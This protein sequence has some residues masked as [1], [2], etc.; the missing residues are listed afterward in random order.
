M[1]PPPPSPSLPSSPG[2]V[3]TSNVPLFCF[4][5]FTVFPSLHVFFVP[6]RSLPL[7]LSVSLPRS[8]GYLRCFRGWREGELIPPAIGGHSST[9]N[10]QQHRVSRD[11]RLAERGAR[12]PGR[13]WRVCL[14]KGF[15]IATLRIP[16]LPKKI[17]KVGSPPPPPPA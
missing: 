1:P 14:E 10:T 8:R 12:R 9:R 5:F 6:P 3:S 4:C 13:A 2:N 16:H 15:P 11:P 17:E 7:S